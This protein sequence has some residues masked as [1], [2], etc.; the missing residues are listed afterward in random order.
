M[1]RKEGIR[2]KFDE[3]GREIE[4]QFRWGVS[5]G[6][7]TYGYN[8]CSLY[9]DG[10]KVGSC[11]GGGY[12][13]KG[14]VLGHFIAAAFDERLR[15]RIGNGVACEKCR[16]TGKIEPGNIILGDALEGAPVDRC[17]DCRGSGRGG[18]YYGLVF[19]DPD[20]D[21][22]SAPSPDNPGMTVAEAEKAGKSLG[23]ERYQAF[24]GASAP[25][26]DERHRI[27]EI[28]W[29]IGMSA[30]ESIA[31]GVGLSIRY[32]GDIPRGGSAYTLTVGA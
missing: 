13:M 7:D 18:G 5:R 9:A 30:V 32:R 25:L 14:T 11:N 10:F 28:H 16:G 21:P 3:V 29:G 6:R 24:Y 8:I 4:L 23:L 2:I 22:G 27:P 12:D 20:Y 1:A 15:N 31:K 26:P 17:P 19:H